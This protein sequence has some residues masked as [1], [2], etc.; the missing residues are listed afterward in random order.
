MKPLCLGHL[1]DICGCSFSP[2]PLMVHSG[3]GLKCLLGPLL[4][5]LIPSQNREYTYP[6]S[7]IPPT[8][9]GSDIWAIIVLSVALHLV[10]Q[11]WWWVTVFS[12]QKSLTCS[13]F[14][15]SCEW[16]PQTTVWL[17]SSGCT[18][19]TI[20]ILKPIFDHRIWNSIMMI[21]LLEVEVLF[22]TIWHNI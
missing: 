15:S 1:S 14:L 11:S 19:F 8:L 12:Q 18:Q 4:T 20:K 7:C 13:I 3:P 22:C 5:L 16:T 2:L 21:F 17:K 9:S 10:W 6:S